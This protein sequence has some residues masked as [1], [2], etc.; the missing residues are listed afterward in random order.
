MSV[1]EVCELRKYYGKIKAVDGISFSIEEGE[2]FGFLGQNGAGKSTTIRCMMDFIRPLKGSIGILG[3]D[4]QKDSVEL[5]KKI[6]Y[7][8]GDVRLYG[9]WTGQEHIDFFD[10]LN[11][12]SDHAAELGERLDFDPSM[13]V[14]QLSS[15][16]KQKLGIILAFMSRPQIL[17]LDEPTL[18]LDPLL[19]NTIYSML[20]ESTNDGATVF[21]SSHNL[22]EVDRVCSRVGIIR[23]GRMVATENITALKKKKINTMYVEFA[24]SVNKEDFLDEHTD[25]VRETENTLTLKIKG[26]INAIIRRLGSYSINDIRITQ[27]SLEDIFMEYYEKEQPC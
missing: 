18:G 23:L 25:L 2:I 21:M 15:G 9:K 10:R 6:G 17:I 11:G 13:P 5:K 14:R 26:D 1:I 24:G 3:K 4:A 22:A 12:G 19:Q 16:N 8:A 27:A 7:L 20:A